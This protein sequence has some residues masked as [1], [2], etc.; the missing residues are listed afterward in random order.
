MVAVWLVIWVVI[1]LAGCSTQPSEPAAPLD[2]ASIPKPEPRSQY[3]NP[4]SYE[5]R[6]QRY[7]ILNSAQGY[8]ERGIASWYG[9][10]FHGKRTSSR[11]PYDMYAMTAAHTTL[12]LPTYVLVTNLENGRAAIVRVND[13]GP[14]EKNRLLDLSYSGARKLGVYKTGTALVEVRALDPKT[15]DRW[16]K[17]TAALRSPNEEAGITTEPST[18]P[19]PPEP[20]AIQEHLSIYLQVGAFST[21]ENAERLRQRLSEGIGVN[22]VI[23]QTQNTQQTLYRLRLG[24]LKNAEMAEQLLE[25]LDRLGVRDSRVVVD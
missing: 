5:V 11:E 25:P 21:R 6:G 7:Y 12:P 17:N 22:C 15:P 10:N 24:P 19:A 23:T 8:V 3:G 13:R 16:P 14:F 18:T 4:I 2:T 1:T 20:T 9:P